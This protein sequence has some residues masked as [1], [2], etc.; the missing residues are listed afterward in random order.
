[1]SRKSGHR[2][3]TQANHSRRQQASR[4]L[5]DLKATEATPTSISLEISKVSLVDLTAD[6]DMLPELSHHLS[7]LS[8][9][10][11]ETHSLDSFSQHQKILPTS[12]LGGP[13]FELDNAQ[14]LADGALFSEILRSPSESL[15]HAGAD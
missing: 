4:P 11:D 14:L 6:D 9:D 12:L 1:M 8:L 3:K 15:S 7:S 10:T 2:K 5:L 13:E